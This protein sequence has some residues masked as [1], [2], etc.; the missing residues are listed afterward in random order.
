MRPATALTVTLSFILVMG[1][2]CVHTQVKG[3]PV[4]QGFARYTKTREIKAVSPEGVTYRVR[5]EANKPFAQLP[6]WKEALKKRMLDAGYIFLGEAPVTADKREGYLLELTAPYG[7]QDYTYLI[8]VFAL[9]REI[10]IV[11]A[12]GEVTEL[13]A[14]RDDILA[15]IGRLKF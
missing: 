7:Q 12:A 15:A 2:A 9:K 3:E 10:V 4:P 5:S 6:F 14:R 13:T 1:A 8:A 11:E